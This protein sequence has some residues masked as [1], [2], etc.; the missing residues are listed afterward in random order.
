[1]TD[2]NEA[3][4]KSDDA[5][6]GNLASGAVVNGAVSSD[7]SS[8]GIRG[9]RG[10][11]GLGSDHGVTPIPAS[12]VK[13]ICAIKATVEALKKSQRNQHG[14]YNF[15]STD[16]LYAAISKKEGE[17]GV[18]CFAL[19]VENETKRIETVDKEGKTRIVQWLRVVYQFVWATATDTWTDPKNRRT[20]C[21]QY[22]GPQTYQ[23]A[24]SFVEK[25]Y[26]RST[27]KLPSGDMDLDS[28]P[29]AEY[30]DDQNDLLAPRKKK[31]SSAAKKDGTTVV[32]NEL[33]GAVSGADGPADLRLI[34]Q[35]NW[36][37]WESLPRAWREL[38]DAEFDDRMAEFEQMEAAE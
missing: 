18:T 33:R 8:S 37:V 16:D 7:V 5:G 1:M 4:H 34:K 22:T 38:I 9:E 11:N 19:E 31:S 32:F 26:Y 36:T 17:V 25:A 6:A 29:Q 15:S 28:M 23:A 30:E 20:I 2:S 10:A 21:V 14:G 27:Y 3:I 24:Q 35:Q 12:I 13:A